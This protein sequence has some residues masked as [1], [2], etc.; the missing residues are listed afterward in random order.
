MPDLDPNRR[1][2]YELLIRWRLDTGQIAGAHRQDVQLV[3]GT[4]YLL[5]PE[6]LQPAAIA[7]LL[8][9]VAAQAITANA[10]LASENTALAEQVARLEGQLAAANAALGIVPP[11]A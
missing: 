1:A 7:G 5:D 11:A 3:N 9:E 4:P 6:P 10:A 2:S 8:T